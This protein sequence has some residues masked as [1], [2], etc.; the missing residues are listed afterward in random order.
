MYSEVVN[1][2]VGLTLISLEGCKD[3]LYLMKQDLFTVYPSP[4]AGFFLNPT[5]LEHAKDLELFR[6]VYKE[7]YL[8]LHKADTTSLASLSLQKEGLENPVFC[9]AISS[10]YLNKKLFNS[11]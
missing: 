4:T 8:P 5:H 9:E 2:S 10:H 3:T 7:M 11:T 6:Q 1:Y